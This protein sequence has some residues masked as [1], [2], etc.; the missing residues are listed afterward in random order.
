MECAIELR[1]YS[2][3]ETGRVFELNAEDVNASNDRD[4][5]ENVRVMEKQSIQVAQSFTYVFPAHSATVIQIAK[6]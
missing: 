2:P 1:G 6:A 4:G 3:Q 5:K